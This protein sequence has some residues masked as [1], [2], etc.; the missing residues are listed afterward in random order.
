MKARRIILMLICS[1]ISFSVIAQNKSYF[2]GLS[3]SSG[4]LH[5]EGPNFGV[6]LQNELLDVRE[7]DSI[8]KYDMVYDLKNTSASYCTVNASI[9]VNIYFNEFA[10]G[11]RTP[12]LDQ[13]SN[14]PSFSDLF[15][16]QDATL[17]LREQIRQNF[18]QRLF[19]RR[20]V[21]SDNL[22]QLGIY[23][24]VFRNGTRVN[25]KKIMCELKFVD[26]DRLNQTKDTEVL[27]IEIKFMVDLNFQPGEATSLMVFMT[28]PSTVCG[29]DQ[30]EIYSP[31]Q[32][33]FEKGWSGVVQSFYI[34]HDVFTATPIIPSKYNNYKQR[35][36]GERDQVLIFNNVAPADK[37]WFAFYHLT[38]K[39]KCNSNPMFPEQVI[40]P[41]PIKNIVASSY[42]KTGSEITNRSFVQTPLVAVS[43]SINRYQTGNPTSLDLFSKNFT[44]TN[45]TN[46]SLYDYIST[47]CKQDIP[48]IELKESG[49]PV[50]AF[51]ITDFIELDTSYTGIENL[52]KQTCWCEGVPGSGIGEY[53]EFEITQP[54][55]EF[56][57][58][59]GNLI[60]RKIFE[61]YT[62]ADR[63]V[64]T[65]LDGYKLDKQNDKADIK[66]SV[67]DLAIMNV[68]Q[69]KLPPGKYRFTVDNVGSGKTP[70]TC[71]SS[72]M[73]DFIL[74]DEWYQNST[75]MINSFLTK[76]N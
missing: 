44:S 68:Y 29:V 9:P 12:M 21:S 27:A 18:Q 32:M 36:S 70:T 4:N 34:K 48:N 41:S 22:K 28:V 54:V 42:L 33:G 58:F 60:N 16:V 40:I 64:L 50:F 6:T 20:Y 38:D 45:Y 62:K 17:D 5:P 53:L 51:D 74:D 69:L 19:V 11:K 61:E 31:Y 57:I 73:F 72:I 67:I 23:V 76:M 39:N 55:N 3:V 13:L 49:N 2:N 43:D 25:I 66:F 75:N 71:F 7:L 35:F 30:K 37:E 47:E 52:G 8:V 14:M 24:D 59:N 65:S 1:V 26:E 56:M 63:F 15:K 46:G 10:Y